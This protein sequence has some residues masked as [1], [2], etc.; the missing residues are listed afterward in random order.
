MSRMLQCTALVLGLVTMAGFPRVSLAQRSASARGGAPGVV[1]P[2]TDVSITLGTSTVTGRV[3]ANCHVD[4]RA[5]TSNTRAYFVAMYPWFGQRVA[6]DKPQW[7]FD[8]E[9]RRGTASEASDQFVFSF[10]DGQ[11]SGT[12][13]TVS[14]SERMGSGT[15]RVT[16]HGTGARFEVTGRTKEGDALRATI[17]CSAFQKSEGAG[18]FAG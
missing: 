12:I 18:G 16:R 8:L 7:R 5:T 9:I 13:Q 3:D 10:L 14:G 17:D 4:E 15:V 6:P 11:R 1:T 2:M